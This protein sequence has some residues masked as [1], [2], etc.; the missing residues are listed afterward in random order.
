MLEK[1]RGKVYSVLLFLYFYMITCTRNKIWEAIIQ[2]LDNVLTAMMT[3]EIREAKGNN[4][5][6]KRYTKVLVS[7]NIFMHL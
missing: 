1:N 3:A 6:E 5:E 4:G 7:V 2:V